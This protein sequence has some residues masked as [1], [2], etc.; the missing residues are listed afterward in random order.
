MLNHSWCHK[1]KGGGENW[2]SLSLSLRCFFFLPLHVAPFCTVLVFFF[3]CLM[4]PWLS[5]VATG[6]FLF[7]FVFWELALALCFFFFRLLLFSSSSSFSSSASCIYILGGG[8]G[9]Q[10][11]WWPKTG[12]GDFFFGRSAPS[13]TGFQYLHR[14]PPTPPW[15]LLSLCFHRVCRR[16]SGLQDDCS[17]SLLTAA[18]ED[19]GDRNEIRLFTGLTIPEDKQPPVTFPHSFSLA[20]P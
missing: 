17:Q 6:F 14:F 13:S 4:I 7:F 19:G 11:W 10:T 3:R 20:R 9:I 2:G 15:L 12:Q 18:F 5:F 16:Q 1:K 8:G